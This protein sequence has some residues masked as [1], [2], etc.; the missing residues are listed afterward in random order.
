[1]LKRNNELYG[2]NT[3]IKSLNPSKLKT[4]L[5][6]GGL[7][8]AICVY[9]APAYAQIDEVVVQA[10]KAEENLQDVP[11]SVTA[12]PGD[13]L[14]DSGITEFPQIAQITPNFDIRSDEV[15]GEFA[16][17]VNIRGQNSTTSDLTIDQAVGININGAPITRGTN[18]FGNLFDIEQVEILR[19]PQGT[20]FGKNTTG[21]TVNVTTKA[22]VLGEF[23]GYGE[24]T[25]GNFDR[26][27]YEGVFNVPVGENSAFRF[28]AA[29]TNRDGFA[30][31]VRTDGTLSGADLADDDE[32]FYRI[33]FLT[34]P[35]D[36][37]S[38]RLNADYHE[39]DENGAAIQA[40]ISAFPIAS[41]LPPSDDFFQG[42]DFNNGIIV[43]QDDPN[44]VI[45]DETNVNGTV[46]LDLGF[47]ELTSVT[48]Y[49]EQESETSLNFSPLGAIIIG[50]DSNLFAQEL[51]LAGEY[52][53]LQWQFGGFYSDESGSDRNNTVGRNQITDVEN[54][55]IPV[56]AQGA[57]LSLIHI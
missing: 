8:G 46:K 51:R 11:I 10:R 3:L 40:Q 25:I 29:S 9:S 49:R 17:V 26:N 12:L 37:L 45:A 35:N 19:G 15:R 27:D 53:N 5:I 43:P 32:V 36:R 21:G 13:V 41:A 28:G 33:S 48:S 44:S 4:L 30:D 34:E 18:L 57:Y 1:M 39:V 14:L 54:E 50:Q 22:P 42:A 47:A 52:N 20:L 56:F 31:G 6:S 7:V 2:E 16:A 24:V 55:T 38:I 23:S